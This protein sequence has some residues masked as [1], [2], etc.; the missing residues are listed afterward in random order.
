MDKIR[1]LKLDGQLSLGTNKLIIN[2]F[3]SPDNDVTLYYGDCMNLLKTIPDNSSQ[4]VVTSPP[5]NLGKEYEDK[6]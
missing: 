1:N 6:R 5:Y 2:P 4:L 3:Y